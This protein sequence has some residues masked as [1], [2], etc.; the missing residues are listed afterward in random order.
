ME[1]AGPPIWQPRENRARGG[2]D[3]EEREAG[4]ER[5]APLAVSD[6]HAIQ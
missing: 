6:A 5:R 4:P 2:D 1:A 3:E